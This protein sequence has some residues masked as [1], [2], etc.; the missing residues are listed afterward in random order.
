MKRIF[1]GRRKRRKGRRVVSIFLILALLL[2]VFPVETFAP[3]VGNMLAAVAYAA[4]SP[5]RET[6]TY[7][8]LTDFVSYS[9]EYQSNASTY[10]EDTIILTLNN[11]E[12]HYLSENFKSLGTSEYPFNGKIYITTNFGES[13]YFNTDK[14]LFDY[15]TDSVTICY[16]SEE[17]KTDPIPI[18]LRRKYVDSTQSVALSP[19]F[20]N[21]VTHD[22][23]AVTTWKM[24][25]A[26]FVD[27]QENVNTYHYSGLIGSMEEDAEVLVEFANNSYFSSDQQTIHSDVKGTEDIGL[28]CGEMKRGSHISLTLTGTNT[29]CDVECTG[30]GNAGGLVGTMSAGS[31]LTMKNGG[32]IPDGDR[33][34]K[35]AKGY[36]GGLVGYSD[37]GLVLFEG[38]DGENVCASIRGT[39]EGTEAAGGLYGYYRNAATLEDG[40]E[41]PQNVGILLSNYAVDCTVKAP[42]AGGL[43]GKL[44]GTADIAIDGSGE[45]A[46]EISVRGEGANEFGGIVG[47]YSTSALTNTFQVHE[48]VINSDAVPVE[49]GLYGGVAGL[50]D[51][52]SATYIKVSGLTH[53]AGSGFDGVGTFGGVVGNAGENGSF[54]DV[55]SVTI[56]TGADSA[57]ANGQPFTGGG[58]V[59]ILQSGV[60]RLSGTTNLQKAPSDEAN[61]LHQNGQLV[62]IR[63]DALVYAVGSG[64]D[65]G[66]TLIR[67][68]T[69]VLADDIGTW[70]C[71]IRSD[72]ANLPAAS[73]E[74]LNADATGVLQF[75]EDDHTVTV[76]A[77]V[78]TI[79]D[80]AAYTATALNMQLNNGSK[81]ALLFADE[82]NKKAVLLN[83]DLT[84]SGTI[85]L[86]GTGNIGLMR[87]DYQDKISEIGI[88]TGTI[89]GGTL[90]LAIGERYAYSEDAP[91][92]RGAI[93]GHRYN[94]LIARA[95]AA[96]ATSGDATTVTSVVFQDITVGGSIIVNS[97][98]IKSTVGGL[99]AEANDGITLSN[100][101]AQETIEFQGH[102]GNDEHTVYLVGGMVGHV[103]DKS[104]NPIEI[105]GSTV[106]SVIE[107]TGEIGN[108][109]TGSKTRHSVGG[110]IGRISAA[111]A[112]EI[113]IDGLTLGTTITMNGTAADYISAA[114]M[115]ADIV[116]STHTRTMN[117]TDV[118]ISDTSIKTNA[119][120]HAG[121]LLGMRWFR[122]D[123]N[124]ASESGVTVSGTNTVDAK[125]SA[126]AG[127][128]SIAT[129]HWTVPKNGI[130]ITGL[131]IKSA[132]KSLGILVHDGYN[133]NDGLYLELTDKD[134]YIL[135]S[136]LTIPATTT[137]DELVASTG[138]SILSNRNNGIISITTDGE[139]IMDGSGCNTYQNKYNADKLNNSKSRYYYNLT[140]ICEKSTKT[141]GEKLLLWSL[142]QYAASNISTYFPTSLT[143]ISGTFDMQHLSYYPID[144]GSNVSIGDATFVFYNDEI[145]GGE[146][147]SGNS[148]AVGEADGNRTTR[149]ASQ[150]YLMHAGLFRNV[151][152]TVTTKGN[153]QFQGS[154]GVDN[155]YS[156]A[157]ICGTI[158][159]KLSTDANREIVLEGLII[160]DPTRYL[161]INKLATNSKMT[162]S[163]VRTGG[164]KDFANVD[165]QASEIGY[166]EGATVAASLI[167]DVSGNGIQIVFD[168]IKLDSRT[169]EG[170]PDDWSDLYGTTKSIFSKA[171][172]LNKF[173]VDNNSTGTYNFNE[174]EDWA[175]SVHKANVTYGKEI[176]TSVEY[177]GKQ[178]KYYDQGNF[179]DPE[180]QPSS[181][182]TE[183]YP[184]DGGFLPYVASST[185]DGTSTTREL[186][187]NV[188]TSGLVEGCGT[189]NHPY[190][191]KNG[192]QLVNVATSMNKSGYLSTLRLPLTQGSNYQGAI[193]SHWCTDRTDC[194]IFTHSDANKN[195][196]YTDDKNKKYTW[197]EDQ[198]SLYLA[199]A[200]YVIKNDITINKEDK[201]IGLGASPT[202]DYT[203]KYAFRGVI[204]GASDS[205]TVKITNKSGNFQCSNSSGNLTDQYNTIGLI[206]TS[207]G[208]VVKNL[209][210]EVDLPDDEIYHYSSNSNQKYEYSE[211]FPNY[212]AVINKIMGG[213]NIIDNV[214]V[215][216]DD[217]F[218]VYEKN[219]FKATVGGYVGCVVNGGLIFRNVDDDSLTDFAVKK[220]GIKNSK[221]EVRTLTV[222][223]HAISSLTDENDLV[224]LH[225]NPFVGR[226]INGYAIRESS[227]VTAKDEATGETRT[228]ETA[229]YAFSEDG[230]TYGDGVT[231]S[232]AV[233]VTMHNTRKNY[234]IPDIDSTMNYQNDVANGTTNVL[235]F[236]KP[237]GQTTYNTI[238]V[239]NG[240]ALY[241]MSIIAQ[242]G[243]GCAASEYSANEGSKYKYNISY[244]GNADRNYSSVSTAKSNNKTTH[245]ANYDHVGTA[246]DT[247]DADYLLSVMDTVGGSTVVPYIIYKYTSS[248]E[249]GGAKYPARTLT[250]RTYYV[251]LIAG[252]TY[253]LP[254]SFRGIGFL[255]GNVLDD[256][257][258]IYGFNGNGTEDAVTVIDVNTE[259]F[260]NRPED[261]PYYGSN[262][263]AELTTGIALFNMLRQSSSTGFDNKYEKDAKYQITGFTLQGYLSAH[264][265]VTTTGKDQI[266][267][268][269]DGR[270]KKTM[271]TA[272]FVPF[273]LTDDIKMYNFSNIKFQGL[274]IN[275][276]SYAAGFIG[277]IN[278]SSIMIYINNCNADG[279][280]I[281][282]C[283]RVAGFV[284]SMDSNKRQ[285]A[286][287]HVNTGLDAEGKDSYSST[288]RNTIINNRFTADTKQNYT[289]GI[290]G[291]FYTSI[292][293]FQTED[294]GDHAYG[295]LI[296]RNVTIEGG[297]AETN[298]IGNKNNP[299]G[300]SGG[301]VGGG[302]GGVQGCLI[303]NCTVKDID[304]YGRYAG[305]IFGENANRKSSASK[306]GAKIYGCTVTGT[307]DDEGNPQ[308]TIMAL[309][310]AGG[311]YGD[312]RDNINNVY[313]K[314]KSITAGD[315]DYV[316]YKADIDGMYVYGY[317]IYSINENNNDVTEASVAG[318]NNKSPTSCGAGGITGNNDNNRK[319]QN[320]KVEKCVIDIGTNASTANNTPSGGL[321]GRIA[322]GTIYGYNI[323]VKDCDFYTH[324][325]VKA[326]NGVPAH[327]INTQ[328][329]YDTDSTQ[330]VSGMKCGNLIGNGN[331]KTVNLVAVHVENGPAPNDFNNLASSSFTVYADYLDASSKDGHGIGMSSLRTLSSGY[332]ET[333]EGGLKNYFPYVNVSPVTHMGSSVF[334]TG[335]GVALYE[336]AGTS[337]PIMDAIVSGGKY[338]KPGNTVLS[339]I[340]TALD[341]T[342]EGNRISTFYAE[343]GSLPEG[344]EDFAVVVINTENKVDSTN[345]INYYIQMAT[346]TNTNYTK[347]NSGK[348]V[349]KKYPCTFD[350]ASGNYVINA[351]G[352][353]AGLNYSSDSSQ[354]YM[355]NGYAD[356]NQGDYQFSLLDVQFLKPDTAAT[357]EVVYHLYVPVLTRKM[358][359]FGFKSASLS[360]TEVIGD[361][362]RNYGNTLAE[363]LKSWYTGYIR[364]TYRLSELQNLLDNGTGLDWNSNKTIQLKYTTNS[365]SAKLSGDTQLV[366]VNPYSSD[367]SYYSRLSDMRE[368]SDTNASIDNLKLT[369]FNTKLDGTGTGFAPAT[370]ATMMAAQGFTVTPIN[371]TTG[372]SGYSYQVTT[373]AAKATI[374]IGSSMYE[375]VGDGNGNVKLKIIAPSDAEQAENG[376]ALLKEDYYLCVRADGDSVY[377]YSI[378]TPA[379]I[380][381]GSGQPSLR[382]SNLKENEITNIIMGN[383]YTQAVTIAVQNN[384]TS[385]LVIDETNHQLD[386]ALSTSI[387]LVGSDDD[388]DFIL[389]HLSSGN[390]HLYQSFVVTLT[391]KD[392]TGERTDI[393]GTP[394]VSTTFTING[395]PT[396][397]AL[398]QQNEIEGNCILL[399]EHDIKN[400]LSKTSATIIRANMHINFDEAWQYETE[401]PTQDGSDPTVGVNVSVRSNLAYNTESLLYTNMTAFPDSPNKN[402]YY[403]KESEK[404]ELNYNFK[405]GILDEYDEAGAAS[406][407]YSQQGINPKNFT[408][409]SM[410]RALMET[411]ATYNAANVKRSD[412]VSAK[413]IR[414]VLKLYKKT[415]A[416]ENAEYTEVADIGDYI[417]LTNSKSVF[418]KV[419]SGVTSSYGSGA[420]MIKTGNNALTYTA[421][422][423]QSMFDKQED[424]LFDADISFEVI[425]GEGFKEYAN[426]RFVLLVDL[427]DAD[428]NAV[429]ASSGAMDW[430]VYTNAKINP[431][432][433]SV[434]EA[435]E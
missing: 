14:P 255:G 208:C 333:G 99:V 259:F 271:C 41:I 96:T 316:V 323:E 366:L 335:D 111:N 342:G 372:A 266:A 159:G 54:L 252:N 30:S 286:G 283:G 114:G 288:I 427:I 341:S 188:F 164:G 15:V 395:T 368:I 26:P 363:S 162:L 146:T 148:D 70:G 147:A 68:N 421:D 18:E 156:G 285:N 209:T 124:F 264:H 274:H 35:T 391:A 6:I 134:S 220:V 191:I 384:G 216:F 81:G 175:G 407:N 169:T 93:I 402:Y 336:K 399:A 435:G 298:Y 181:D 8:D 51:G 293:T 7:N 199:S 97:K 280:K 126:V 139:L 43:F 309:Q 67:S 415:G 206:S 390:I 270:D 65:E 428:G 33:S 171:T 400:E 125:A 138:K 231:R 322:S 100:V 150:H 20:A 237:S 108:S 251:N 119:S 4:E 234:S 315:T 364:Y 166:S 279:F 116:Y 370:F 369:N 403:V 46:N 300:S 318:S 373:D 258:K 218:C 88:Y 226:V 190:E 11:G 189:Y 86:F 197:T 151:S 257:M 184:F 327:A 417:E 105:S 287:L 48:V 5:R 377:N 31:V 222:N 212:G 32:F 412:F 246:A 91:A 374:T 25:A 273:I 102:G 394:D 430:V 75:K 186:K 194:A 44:Y 432:M 215:K 52:S 130:C 204:V 383:L 262:I 240:Q 387:T 261:D 49:G 155:N 338:S 207:N 433:L 236:T 128:V 328:K 354:Y 311:V 310:Y 250:Q 416:S 325:W 401:F 263:S 344:V 292:N 89:S 196:T 406:Y 278:E 135:G 145:E 22:S 133:S 202:A 203:G 260:T 362:F 198:V 429:S 267:S 45:G 290:V 90:N 375:Y 69:D 253:Y 302:T 40:A 349:I 228:V 361:N 420:K 123:V 117:L 411:V 332:N 422:I 161:L 388:K 409:K 63:T 94:G 142:N 78:T 177:S 76:S 13:W 347:D 173:E 426:Y 109:E 367:K 312:T 201:F 313:P 235:T 132:S 107:V 405:M 2:S 144:M 153:L 301:I 358:M 12:L 229:H 113:N 103:A 152:G 352:K 350:A 21:H 254:D 24:I 129:G 423:D 331:A 80:A 249:D 275:S 104:T 185:A 183:V 127:L 398:V 355:A 291:C 9:V 418:I 182:R 36:A 326:A 47:A 136:G 248:F 214:F 247:D 58:I 71:V 305:G 242:S 356:S 353:V 376:E 110:V 200:Y 392:A 154:I 385:N 307:L 431:S 245:L 272:G 225:V 149:G 39:M 277:Y 122:T 205:G 160:S 121:G 217:V 167:G 168:R 64:S 396:S 79:T 213:D 87:D 308:Y 419:N 3:E 233:E 397:P 393:L 359:M 378:R 195:Y 230:K 66:W 351:E 170:E 410:T 424:Q 389:N 360:G 348:Y 294:L 317:R 178:Q 297:D 98:L 187:V 38:Q 256:N 276:Y 345:I 324:Q 334:L 337:V 193:Q 282:G 73:L 157:L 239:P 158:S 60:L 172:L 210:I 42:A 223:G 408:D 72:E 50:L 295:N 28:I 346:N 137:Y 92:G 1:E 244:D 224:H 413:K 265:V 34:I 329:A 83:T 62:G 10:C 85:S 357:K 192:T 55:G 284:G 320:C 289:A 180:D 82:T 296:I 106:A 434:T 321:I 143:T 425:T 343:M 232:G 174:D 221:R 303:L 179:V 131:E 340:N 243:S 365:V 57:Y 386:V 404:A 77:P 241:I 19:L 299:M 112:C 314:Y 269:G 330:A 176:K 16:S 27:A 381:G 115:I 53:H 304:I 211:G 319:I 306:T 268:H 339:A 238:T 227:T 140:E 61:D 23:G 382:V 74:S 414:F 281:E 219:D 120:S 37:G 165:Q 371:G 379:T 29:F 17:H 95:G 141:D 101:T 56:T 118:T 84:V 59:G 163:G 380:T